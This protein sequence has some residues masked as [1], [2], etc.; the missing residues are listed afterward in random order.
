MPSLLDQILVNAQS[1]ADRAEKAA[2]LVGEMMDSLG[3][4]SPTPSKTAA[5]KAGKRRGKK[6]AEDAFPTWEDVARELANDKAIDDLRNAGSL[7]VEPV[8]ASGESAIWGKRAKDRNTFAE[9]VQARALLARLGIEE[10][11]FAS[12]DDGSVWVIVSGDRGANALNDLMIDP[13]FV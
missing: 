1:L 7:G 2:S 8:G 6:A 3:Q 11:A 12:S 9:L 5:L 10:L 13:V 4:E